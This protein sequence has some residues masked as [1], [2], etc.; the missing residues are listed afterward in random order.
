MT[1]LRWLWGKPSFITEVVQNSFEV[2]QIMGFVLYSTNIMQS[3]FCFF[4]L[5]KLVFK[6]VNTQWTNADAQGAKIHKLYCSKINAVLSSAEKQILNV[7]LQ[8]N[9]YAAKNEDPT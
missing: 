9:N 7:S 8:K 4:F 6:K 5:N 3:F 1:S 2:T